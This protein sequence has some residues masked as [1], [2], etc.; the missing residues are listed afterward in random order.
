MGPS[1]TIGATIP[2]RCNFGAKVVVF[3]CPREAD[4]ESLALSLGAV[5]GLF[6]R[7]ILCR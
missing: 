5:L 1:R 3:Q 7:V 6:L 4:S 2:F